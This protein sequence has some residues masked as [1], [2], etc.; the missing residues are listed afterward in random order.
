MVRDYINSLAPGR[1]L[2]RRSDEGQTMIEYALI[3][4]VIVLA[5]I[6]AYNATGLGSAIE[7]VFSDTKTE[8]ESRP[9]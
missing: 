5:L 7:E 1:E 4:G 2:L 9:S 8:L 3:I 6:I